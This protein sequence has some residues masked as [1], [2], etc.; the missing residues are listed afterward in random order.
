MYLL[1]R[2]SEYTAK[3]CG[4][5]P[6]AVKD[7]NA[8]QVYRE[9]VLPDDQ[10]SMCDP[11]GYVDPNKRIAQ[12]VEAGLRIDA[13]NHAVYDM[14]HPDQDTG[15]DPLERDDW[16]DLDMLSAAQSSKERYYEEMYR[17]YTA[18]LR[19]QQR[20]SQEPQEAVQIDSVKRV[21]P[22]V[23]EKVDTPVSK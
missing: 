5:V 6:T 14:E 21:D 2:E 15:Q 17:M 3:L 9:P 7:L 13:W 22:E 11:V 23:S 20:A 4:Y 12:M 16:D 10:P 1:T 18:S 8:H 19:S